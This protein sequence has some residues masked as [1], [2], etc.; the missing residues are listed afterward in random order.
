MITPFF[1]VRQDDTFVYIDV[2]INHVRFS[3]AAIEMVVEGPLFVFLLAPYYLRLR[4]PHACVDDERSHAE[5]DSKEECVKIKVP[6]ANSGEHFEDLDLT[7]KLLARLNEP[8]PSQSRPLIEEIGGDLTTEIQQAEAFDWEVAQTAAPTPTETISGGRYG[9]GNNYHDIIG[10]SVANGNDIN[11]LADP[12]HTSTDNRVV[13]RLIKENIKFDPEYYAADYIMQQHPSPD[14]D[15]QLAAL[16]EWRSPTTRA[17]LKWYKSQQGNEHAPQ[18]MAD[19]KFSKKEQEQMLDL[20]RKLYLIEPGSPQQTQSLLVL[21]AL[22]FSY[23][24]DMRETEGDHNIESAW[25]VGRLTPQI[26]M[27]DA[28]LVQSATAELADSLLQVQVISSTRRALAYPLHR[29]YDLVQRVWDDVYHNLRGGKRLVIKSLLD[30]RELFRFHDVYYVYNKIWIDDLCSWLIGDGVKEGMI[31]AL[32]HDLKKAVASVQK[33][34]V[35]FE[36]LESSDD[37]E[38]MVALNID[39]IEA[40]ARQL[41]EEYQAN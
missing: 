7:A 20:P 27:L 4:L 36:K 34:D 29:N 17:F 38:D 35:T 24:F 15:K 30:L 40:M 19:V 41:Y 31:R 28:Q 5:Y 22:L 6:K 14:D 8:A 37:S 2:K 18:Y 12:E 25:T 16:L 3:A 1:T 10:V 33:T 11:E 32:A 13:E 9:F 26:A 21:V 23:H 39:D